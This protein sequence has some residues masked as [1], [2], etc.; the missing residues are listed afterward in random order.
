MRDVQKEKSNQV[1][2]NSSLDH[3]ASSQMFHFPLFQKFIRET[4]ERK[5]PFSPVMDLFALEGEGRRKKEIITTG[6]TQKIDLLT[7]LTSTIARRRRRTLSREAFLRDRPSRVRK[8]ERDL[9]P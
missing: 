1:G 2:R 3:I 7:L 5:E 8:K 6:L 4:Q 9:F